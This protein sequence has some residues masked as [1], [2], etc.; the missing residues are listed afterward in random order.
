MQLLA[1]TNNAR[2]KKWRFY[3]NSNSTL[4]TWLGREIDNKVYIIGISLKNYELD[5]QR[6]TE[7]KE[8]GC[9]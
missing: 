8:I 7:L 4:R 2:D 6:S 1:R 9:F 5:T 3:R